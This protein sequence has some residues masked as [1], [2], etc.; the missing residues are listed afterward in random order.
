MKSDFLEAV[1][2]RVF[3]TASSLVAGLISLK[4]I[5]DHLV[6]EVY[7]GVLVAM[8]VMA[9]LPLLDGGV[10]TVSNRRLLISTEGGARE[11]LLR[12][13]T[14]FYSRLTPVALGVA[15]LLMGAY[16]LTP[17][18]RAVGEPMTYWL[19][20][21]AMG[22]LTVFG[23]AQ[24]A[25]L[26]GL[27]RQTWYFLVSGA[28][29]WVMVLVLWAG[30]RLGA[31]VWAFPLAGLTA[32]VAVLPL[33]VWL[34]RRRTPGFVWWRF[35]PDADYPALRKEL[36]ADAWACF[37]SQLATLLLFTL[38]VVLAG[39]VCGA[40]KEAAIYGVL[41]RL[42]GIVRSLAQAASEVAWPLVAHD[43]V[44]TQ[45]LAGF[46]LRANAWV[47]GAT[48]GGMV[49]TVGPFVGWWMGA[50]WTPAPTVVGLLAARLLITGVSAP[51]AYYL[52]GQG[53][54]LSLAK[55][56]ERELA[57]AVAVAVA[58]GLAWG[59]N[60]VAAGFLVATAAGTL[61]PILARYAR[62][63]QQPPGRLAGQ[64]WWRALL[65]LVVSIAVATMLLPPA[66]GEARLVL[67]G[68][69]AAA[70]GLGAGGV[71]A[72][73]R[74]TARVRRGLSSEHFQAM[75]RTF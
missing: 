2:C 69:A 58:A 67:V 42:F 48:L 16:A 60:G 29:A 31:G 25:L 8:Q 35:Q 34:I 36:K 43:A 54:F 37:R 56:V 51:A 33:T 53:D 66:G 47:Y 71:V 28:A 57:V 15:A 1:A 61:L 11:R 13:G 62:S 52:I 63:A 75:L 50:D 18:G 19:A 49:L 59:V 68:A 20:V 3:A 45:V 14:V 46:V 12:F 65:G 22:A 72:W 30:L 32:W 44:G 70:A 38:D 9:C 26:V 74:V 6:P 41:A 64:L 4:L 17:A 7:A 23:G 27:G 73:A 21:G 55:L 10:R 5:G 40:T 24:A 39:V